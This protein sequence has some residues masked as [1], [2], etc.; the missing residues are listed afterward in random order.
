MFVQN[1][2][3]NG[4]E[5]CLAFQPL[6]SYFTRLTGTNRTFSLQFKRILEESIKLHLYLTI[7]ASEK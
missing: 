6:S 4:S 3:L 1:I 2:F 5:N 7:F